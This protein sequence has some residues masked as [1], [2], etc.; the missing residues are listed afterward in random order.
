MENLDYSQLKDLHRS[1]RENYTDE[2]SIRI[3]RS[4]SW[5]KRAEKQGEDLDA[6]FIFYWIAFNATYTGSH[7]NNNSYSEKHT[8]K[9]FFEKILKYDLEEYIY[10]AI[11][12]QFSGSVRNLLNNQ[13]IFSSFWNFQNG[14]EGFEDW[15]E[16]F[17]QSKSM[18][19]K[20]LEHKNTQ[21][22]LEIL[23]DRLY[24]L[25]NQLMHG[26]A[27]WNG[28]VNR[29]Q[30]TDGQSI[31]SFLVPNFLEI[32]MNNQNEDWGKLSFPVV[33]S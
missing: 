9:D 18:V 21:L 32:M 19:L 22:I 13:F 25:R 29:S 17:L 3:H 10:N 26:G 8:Y 23:F 14:H 31:I 4:L 2:F 6:C 7:S 33:Q 24:T 20:A 15:E 30:V 11:W 1:K 12:N 27:T 16:K 5:V 28:K